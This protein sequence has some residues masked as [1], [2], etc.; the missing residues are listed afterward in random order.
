MK[1]LLSPYWI[2]LSVVVLSLEGCMVWP[3]MTETMG[4]RPIEMGKRDQVWYPEA[5][6][7]THLSS[8]FGES[9]AAAKNNQILNPEASKDVDV[10]EGLNG[11]AGA[12]AMKRYQKFFDKPPF[13]SKKGGGK[14]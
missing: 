10:V 7:P 6:R 5:P 4:N 12:K 9:H 2:L 8:D 13:N 3:V 1:K 11:T 14:K